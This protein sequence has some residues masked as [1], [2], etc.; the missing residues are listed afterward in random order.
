M[1]GR[2]FGGTAARRLGVLLTL[3]TL[4]LGSFAAS[5]GSACIQEPDPEHFTGDAGA[6]CSGLF[7]KQIP[8]S[9]CPGCSGSAYAL[10]N[11]NTF[12]QCACDLP[13]Y[14]YLDAGTLDAQVVL[15]SD[16]GL[17]G[18]DGSYLSVCCVGNT[19]LEIPGSSCDAGCA[20]TVGY[21]LCHDNIFS[22]CTCSVPAGYTLPTVTCDGG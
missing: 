16:G 15:L 7:A 1:K 21:A 17:S 9:E 11:G 6:S 19:Y 4:G 10:C 22:E 2:W 13:S 14:Y 12:N 5:F 20:S 3:G 18:F 8:A